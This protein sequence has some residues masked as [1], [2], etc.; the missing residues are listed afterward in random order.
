MFH[1]RAFHP[2]ISTQDITNCIKYNK[3]HVQNTLFCARLASPEDC[4]LN[5]V[6]KISG[7]SNNEKLVQVFNVSAHRTHNGTRIR[8]PTASS[9]SVGTEPSIL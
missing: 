1:L 9:R 4:E 7:H 2:G 8:T 3:N 5:P 6:W